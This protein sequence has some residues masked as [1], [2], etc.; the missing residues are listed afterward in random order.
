MGYTHTPPPFAGF[1]LL[2]LLTLA[3]TLTT[4]TARVDVPQTAQATHQA[5]TQ[6]PAQATTT[7][8]PT[9]TARPSML[10]CAVTGSL[11]VRACG[12]T[13]CAVIDWL[14][15][16]Q[17]AVVVEKDLDWLYVERGSV[18]GWVNGEFCMIAERP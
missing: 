17:I 18:R 7:P 2:A 8:K 11:N 9:A 10:T 3:C 6:S 4:S 12:S 14:Y 1:A 15:K 5:A 13:A 16:D